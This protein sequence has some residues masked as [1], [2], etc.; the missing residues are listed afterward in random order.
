MGNVPEPCPSTWGRGLDLEV[1]RKSQ[2]SE[3]TWDRCL[4]AVRRADGSTGQDA[5]QG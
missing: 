5:G 3:L 1:S 2:S 4:G